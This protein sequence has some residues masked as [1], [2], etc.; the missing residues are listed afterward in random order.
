VVAT[1]AG[2]IPEVVRDGREGLLAPAGDVPALTRALMRIRRDP[3]LA[4]RLADAGPERAREFEIGSVVDR[5]V[6]LYERLRTVAPA[7]ARA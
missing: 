5:I 4:R 6:S 2:G 3:G 7:E 1:S